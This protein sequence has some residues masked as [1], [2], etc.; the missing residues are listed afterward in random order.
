MFDLVLALAEDG[1]EGDG[2]D[3]LDE[4]L[5]AMLGEPEPS[6]RRRRVGGVGGR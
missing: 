2:R 5:E 1:H 4:R 3:L 6:L